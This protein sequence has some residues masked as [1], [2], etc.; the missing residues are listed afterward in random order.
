VSGPTVLGE[1]S[2]GGRVTEY[3]YIR[4]PTFFFLT[5]TPLGVNPALAQGA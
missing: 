1:G 3:S 2:G 4:G 5:G